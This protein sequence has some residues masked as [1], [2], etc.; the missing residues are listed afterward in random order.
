MDR[1]WKVFLVASA[2]A[3]VAF[4]DVTIVS[5]AFPDIERD[6]PE[7]SRS[8]L[9]WVLSGYNIVFA[10]LL[11]PA[12]RIADVVG[13]KRVFLAGL[14]GFTA[15]SALCAAAP[16]VETLIAARIVQAAA[17]AAIIPTS[18]AFV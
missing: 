17:A 13:R 12:G 16:S 11:V 6:F 14:A 18:L 7:A 5:V 8:S 10:A 4:L 1:R 15:A 2:G 9:A 3:L